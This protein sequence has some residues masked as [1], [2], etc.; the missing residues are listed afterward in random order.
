MIA[1][2]TDSGYIFLRKKARV[3]LGLR[4]KG[5]A[6]LW[7]FLWLTEPDVEKW[8]RTDEGFLKIPNRDK[9]AQ[10]GFR[11][12]SELFSRP[13]SADSA[14]PTS[15]KVRRLWQELRPTHKKLLETL[16][17]TPHGQLSQVELQSRLGLDDATFRSCVGGLAKICKRL[18][19]P[20]P[21]VTSGYNQ[22]SRS[23]M[24]TPAAKSTVV[25][26]S[27]NT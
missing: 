26:V 14:V 17:A 2:K 22:Q 15:H 9:R 11:V 1:K 19:V 12:A 13:P 16:A 7:R 10:Y 3:E 4:D 20:Y 5:A 21:L 24:L 25:A 23:Y 27:T 18:A 6:A 8:A